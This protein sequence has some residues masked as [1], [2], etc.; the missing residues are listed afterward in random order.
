MRI[1]TIGFAVA[2]ST[3]ICAFPAS[4]FDIPSCNGSTRSSADLVSDKDDKLLVDF[5][6]VLL[7]N[8]AAGGR[9]AYCL[10]DAKMT[11][12]LNGLSFGFIQHDLASNSGS[13]KIL[14]KILDSVLASGPDTGLTQQDIDLVKSGALDIRA[15]VIRASKD[16]RL[17]ALI[18]RIHHALS[19]NEI[20]AAEI[21]A[22]FTLT[23]QRDAA[24]LQSEIAPVSDAVKSVTYLK[25]NRLGQL[26]VLDYENFLGS[27]GPQFKG[28]LAGEPETLRGTEI[29]IESPASFTDMM[30]FYLSTKQGAGGAS[31]QRAE[32]LRRLNT[33]IKIYKRNEGEIPLS[34]RDKA[35]LT[36]ELRPMINDKSNAFIQ[37]KKRGHQYDDLVTL[38]RKAA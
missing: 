6:D 7:E 16:K 27:M 31:D 12:G 3:I 29:K 30:R 4:A 22:D 5:V 23:V 34:D 9:V 13:K 8:E 1:S 38:I 24:R 28:Y 15:P 19:G 2:L 25:T 21:N 20:A 36:Q 14:A 17:L 11:N 35:F 33:I 26:V 18:Q 32:V 37:K 10:S